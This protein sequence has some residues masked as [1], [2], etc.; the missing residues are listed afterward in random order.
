MFPAILKCNRT[1]FMAPEDMDEAEAEA[2]KEAEAESDK[3]EERYRS[4]V[5]HEPMPGTKQNEDDPG[6]AWVIKVVG[7]SQQY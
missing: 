7:D 4:I 3:I 1:T 6:L 2:W 5:E